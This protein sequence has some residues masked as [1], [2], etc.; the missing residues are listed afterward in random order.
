LNYLLHSL[1]GPALD[2]INAFPITDDNYPK[3]LQ[4]LNERFDNSTLIFL[5]TIAALFKLQQVVKSKLNTVSR[6]GGQG[7]CYV[8]STGIPWYRLR[9]CPGHVDLHRDHNSRNKWNESL[10]F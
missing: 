9:Y 7:I 1:I 10:D 3:A 8:W 6:L 4:R 2:A 5:E